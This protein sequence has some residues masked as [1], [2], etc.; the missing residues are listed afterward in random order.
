MKKVS[1][2]PIYERLLNLTPIVLAALMPLFFLP[3]TTEFYEF[4]KQLLLIAATLVLL[5]SWALKSVLTK[6]VEFTKSIID[7]PLLT[8]F[9]V[10]IL[11]TVFSISK[12]DS[13][14]GSTGRWF[15]SI[16][17]CGTLVLFYYLVSSG[18]NSTDTIKKVVNALLASVTLNT[19]VT[20]LSY[21][22]VYFGKAAFLQSPSF[23]L[24]GSITTTI[25]L[26][27]IAAVLSLSLVVYNSKNVRVKAAYMA[28]VL[29]NV[30][31]IA[32][33]NSWFG[34]AMLVLGVVFMVLIVKVKTLLQCKP[35]LALALAFTL[36][37][38][39]VRNVPF[40]G[41]Y[42]TNANFPYEIALPVQTSWEI[43]TG[44]L[45]D[46]PYLA[47]GPSTFYLDFTRYRPSVLNYTI[48][49]NVRFDKPFNEA[50][51]VIA[52]LGLLGL[53][54]AIFLSTRVFSLI[55]KS[56]KSSETEYMSR[57]LALGL[58]TASLTFFV[59]YATN[60]NTFVVVL[61]LALLVKSL[62]LEGG[63]DQIVK[64]KVL[65]LTKA[66]K[67]EGTE[68]QNA[69]KSIWR[70]L[71]LVPVVAVVAYTG[72]VETKNF[73][74][75]Y[76]TRMSIEESSRNN[77]SK[78]YTYQENAIK[79]FPVKDTL[80]N[81]HAQTIL[82]LANSI[83]A[84]KDLTDEDKNL[85]QSLIG[86]SIN[87]A[88]TASENVNPANVRNWETR[89]LIYKNVAQIAQNAA[90]WSIAS[91]N[92]AIQLDPFNPRLR[93]DLG[94]M[95]YAKGDYL[96]AANQFRQAISLK[97]D[98]ANAYYNFAQALFQLQDF[99]NAKSALETT[100]NLID[101]NSE[102]AKLVSKEIEIVNQTLE[103]IKA[104]TTKPTVEQIQTKD[105]TTKTDQEPLT[106]AN[107]TKPN[108]T[109]N[110]TENKLEG[111]QP[112]K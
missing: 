46:S 86:Q 112:T 62:H 76:Y 52:E 54:A 70:F 6:Q 53:V 91:Y 4:N 77:W 59:T 78:V 65:P 93:L 40:T 103:A 56:D 13:L 60:L 57:V 9:G 5:V 80:Y 89:A 41:K 109:G 107:E 20:I 67:G 18:L 96:S 108:L 101:P 72:Y 3:I 68:V 16:L 100:K 90:D 30:T 99:A 85:V 87:V 38:A 69:K 12:A 63:F 71:L 64:S 74:S 45:R 22:G 14:Y 97:N 98:Y 105:T 1:A 50:L 82:I 73:L 66:I 10:S 28:G 110:L 95:Y 48:I 34:W 55:K 29:L 84:K 111:T 37:F 25:V 32:L 39:L 92:L 94:G 44:I 2:I 31:L 15:P 35:G 26:A 19:L 58:A 61:L 79:V 8:F 11:A 104:K 24:T 23:T 88:K 17:G 36:V 106:K 43:I 42:L 7:L 49:W 21:L 51:N 83:A 27:A 75:E 81:R 102:D 33:V 47:S